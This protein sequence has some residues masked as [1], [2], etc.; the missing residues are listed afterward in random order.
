MVSYFFYKNKKKALIKFQKL[1]TVSEET[2]EFDFSFVD[3]TIYDKVNN[4][5]FSKII[6]GINKL[7]GKG[8][9][10]NTHYRRR[11]YQKLHYL[12]PQFDHSSSFSVGDIKFPNH[13]ILEEI[14]IL[15][16]QI[17]NGEAVI[18]YSFTLKRDLA[19]KDFKEYVKKNIIDLKNFRFTPYWINFDKPEPDKYQIDNMTEK[20][21]YLLFQ[22]FIVKH[23]HSSIG[24][25]FELPRLSRVVVENGKKE[26][27]KQLK[28]PFIEETFQDNKGNYFLVHDLEH[29]SGIVIEQFICGKS[30]PYNETL[31]NLFM[32]YKM[33]AYLRFFYHIEVFQ[34][35]K[36]MADFL[37]SNRRSIS[38]KKYKWILEKL[39]L[40]N[41]VPLFKRSKLDKNNLNGY[42]E[43]SRLYFIQDDK[44]IKSFRRTYKQ[45]LEYL[46]AVHITNYN[47][48]ILGTTIV[49]LFLTILGIVVTVLVA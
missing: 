24:N 13:E 34:L 2:T 16:T 3:F 39:V 31:L 19:S 35:E 6:E 36:I 18:A 48:V 30:Y 14:S 46:S 4:E 45:N 32:D 29:Q 5:G 47:S 15:G 7:K 37:N 12:R 38:A 11:K 23:F 21:F 9:D 1:I 26:L 8:V 28:Q 43:K 42:S 40:L 41:E 25:E 27:L 49:T 17:N 22:S 10:C 44:L 33:E 20:Y